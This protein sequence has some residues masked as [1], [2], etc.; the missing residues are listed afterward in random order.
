MEMFRY[1]TLV[2]AAALLALLAILAGAVHAAPTSAGRQTFTASFLTIGGVDKPTFVV[3][4]GPIAGVA[5]ATQTEKQKNGAQVNYVVLR[6]ERGTVRMTAVEPRFGF[7]PN[8]KSCTARASGGGTW[9]ITGGTGPYA[10]LTGKGTFSTGGTAFIQRSA[11]GACRGEK[12]PVKETVFYV[13]IAFRG[14]VTTS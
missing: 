14:T 4:H 8:A 1:R 12:T 2:L 3:A 10:A 11:T 7:T 9:T 5:T 13:R 6:F